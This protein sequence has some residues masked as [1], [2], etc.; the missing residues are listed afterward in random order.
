APGR[1]AACGGAGGRAAPRAAFA[2]SHRSLPS[3]DARLFRL[4]ALHPG[5]GIAADTAAH[6][7]GLSPSEARPILGRLA[8]A[9]LVCE[10]ASG[11]YTVHTL[12][13][14]FAAE[15]AEAAEAAEAESL[16][17]PRHSF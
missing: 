11:R 16:S 15:L 4:V 13:R 5:P 12:L 17:L 1:L 3:A 10:V 14:A 9:H 8:D 2:A 6:L 7:A